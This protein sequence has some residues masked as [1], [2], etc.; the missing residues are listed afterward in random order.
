MELFFRKIGSGYP[1][2]ILHGLYGMSDN[3]MSI[4][5]ILSSKN[6]IWLP[7]LRNH[8]HSPHNAIHTYETMSQDIITF[9]QTNNIY[10]PILIGHSMGGKVA[11]TIAKNNPELLAGLCVVDIA[12][13][14]FEINETQ[15]LHSHRHIIDSLC[16]LELGKIK[17]REEADEILSNSLPSA[18][19][20]AFLLKNLQRTPNGF[21]WLF[22]LP[23][24]KKYLPQIAGGFDNN[25]QQTTITGF[26]VLF[27]KGE[28]SDYITNNDYSHIETIFPSAIIKVIPN[29][30]HWLHAQNSDAF[31]QALKE[32]ILA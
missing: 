12:P 23:V 11:M 14:N 29:A 1:I 26:P 32:H 3:W 22:N 8:G 31:I 25:W 24:L 7:D 18:M 13:K 17:N 15:D 19:L 4:A 5:R 27:A 16:S 6:E 28:Q 9:I 30:G 2:L 21:Q 10:K 20:R